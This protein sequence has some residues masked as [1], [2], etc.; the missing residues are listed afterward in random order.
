MHQHGDINTALFATSAI[1]AA[2]FQG[3]R[4]GLGQHLDVAMGQALLYLNEHALAELAAIRAGPASPTWNFEPSRSRTGGICSGI[5]CSSFRSWPTRSGS[6]SRRRIPLRGDP[7][8][9]RARG[10]ELLARVREAFARVAD[11]DALKLRLAALPTLEAEVRS[12][13]ELAESAWAAER[14]VLA[15]VAPGLRV[16]AA[17]WRGAGPK[18]GS[19]QGARDGGHRGRA[20]EHN[21]AVLE[22]WLALP[23][24]EMDALEARGVLSEAP[25]TKGNR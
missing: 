11:F 9:R 12:T 14:G 17:P 16:P 13:R 15:E 4:V 1:L 23:R 10:E 3:E 24:D 25:R 2:L 20:G 18:S 5:R 8:L 19:R 6:R 22:D 7:A 21:R